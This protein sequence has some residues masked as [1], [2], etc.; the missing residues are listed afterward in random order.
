[1]MENIKHEQLHSQWVSSLSV[2]IPVYGSEMILPQL[3]LRLANVLSQL[4][5]QYEVIL[6][7]DDSPDDSWQVILDLRERYSWLRAINLKRNYGQHNATLCGVRAARYEYIVTMDDDLQHPPEEIAK[8][9]ETIVEGYD[10]VY[11]IPID[12]PHSWWRNQMSRLIKRV[13]AYTMNLP[14]I[15]NVSAFRVFRS[16]LRNAFE[17]FNN[18]NVILDVL[19]SW[20]TTRFGIILV[21]EAQRYKGRSNYNLWKLMNVAMVVLTGFSTKP[22]RLASMIGFGFTLLGL[23]IFIYVLWIY[24]FLGSI[25]GFPFLASIVSLFS[26][27][28]LFS[29]GIIG[30]YLGRV[31]DGSIDRPPYVIG[32]EI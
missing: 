31:F 32:E 4:A 26:G 14:R 9:L 25:P 18:P 17:K 3:V 10:V 19:L 29:L 13:L 8:L 27:I 5:T 7:N 28:Q 2:V 23:F 1:M 15:R 21:T 22:L 24:F 6:V 20:G 12:L 16:H 30:E 11:G